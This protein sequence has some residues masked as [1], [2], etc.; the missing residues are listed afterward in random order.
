MDWRDVFNDGEGVATVADLI[1]A[2]LSRRVLGNRLRGGKWQRVLPGVVVAHSGPVSNQ[3]RYRAA[4]A[5]GGAGSLVSHCTAGEL[6]GLKVAATSIEITV[7]HGRRRAD[8]GFVTVHQSMRTSRWLLRNGV[9]C[10][11]VARTV[12]DISSQLRG[13]DDVRA[14]LSDAV[15]RRLTSISEVRTE[16]AHARRNGS[17]LLRVALAEVTQGT[18]SV[19]EARF[20]RLIRHARIPLPELNVAVETPGGWYTVDALRR[21]YG[22]VVEIDG[23]A[24]HLNAMSWQ[25]DLVRQNNLHAVGIVVLRFPA[26]RLN[27]E[28]DRVICELRATLRTRGMPRSAA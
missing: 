6:V 1:R 3:E 24:W 14:L 25:Q 18:R 21:E 5:Y 9:A 13:L 27:S 16:L 4:L 22:V 2:G 19:A 11:G 15:Q 26:T 7:P 20:L 8:S 28:P 17:G 10:T 12:V 23:M